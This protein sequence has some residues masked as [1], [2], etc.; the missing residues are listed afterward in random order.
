MAQLTDAG[1]SYLRLEP[2]FKQPR[3]QCL[4]VLD[5]SRCS[6]IGD[7]AFAELCKAC[8]SLEE[9]DVS[10]CLRLTDRAI[11]ALCDNCPAV[12]HLSVGNCRRLTDA[13]ACLMA[14]ALWL[15]ALD[16]SKSVRL[17]DAALEVLVVELAG[18]TRLD[19]S[20][21][22]GLTDAVL[23]VIQFHGP[24]L[25]RLVCVDCAGVP[26]VSLYLRRETG[27]RYAIAATAFHRPLVPQASR[28]TRCR[29]CGPQ[30]RPSKSG[31]PK[32]TSRTPTGP[33][34]SRRTPTRTTACRGPCRRRLLLG[35]VSRGAVSRTRR[36]RAS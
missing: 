18:L 7:R 14:D 33:S 32:S 35:I 25:K 29:S 5:I 3:G 23:K 20:G 31:R 19:V 2:E 36:S 21:C 26:A 17:S 34:G 15:E 12:K 13:S 27:W 11:K 24:H 1:L 8:P 6:T 28:P 16:F 4:Q 10:F 22:S 9:V 30:D